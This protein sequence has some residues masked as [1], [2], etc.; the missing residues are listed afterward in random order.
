M[1]FINNKPGFLSNYICK[2][3]NIELI[4]ILIYFV[5][6]ESAPIVHVR[7]NN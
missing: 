4:L 1:E 3:N 2:K 7:L 6:K 5:L